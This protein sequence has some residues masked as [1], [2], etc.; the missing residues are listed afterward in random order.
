[1]A[2]W[3]TRWPKMD[4][5]EAFVL[6]AA[7]PQQKFAENPWAGYRKAHPRPNIPHIPLPL[8]HNLELIGTYGRTTECVRPRPPRTP[9]PA[10]AIGDHRLRG[11]DKMWRCGCTNA[12]SAFYQ[13]HRSS[14]M[15][16][17][18]AAS[19]SLLWWPCSSSNLKWTESE[20]HF[21]AR[22]HLHRWTW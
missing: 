22:C 4:P 6:P 1:M 14:I 15:L 2:R 10:V 5:I 21:G 16:G 20:S 12:A 11:L 13:N 7:L 19:S 18:P 9:N 3:A 8:T 17:R